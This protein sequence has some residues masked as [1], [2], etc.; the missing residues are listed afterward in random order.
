MIHTY[1]RENGNALQMD[2][3][4]RTNRY[5]IL[6]RHIVGRTNTMN[7]LTAELCFMRSEIESDNI[8]AQTEFVR[9]TG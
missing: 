8:W 9:V 2:S 5:Y 3:T 1:T 7:M 4:Y 6:L